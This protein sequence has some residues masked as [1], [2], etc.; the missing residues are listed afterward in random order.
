MSDTFNLKK[1]LSENKLTFNSRMLKENAPS[2]N[3]QGNKDSGSIVIT[4]YFNSRDQKNNSSSLWNQV[5]GLINANQGKLNDYTVT[6]SVA[7]FECIERSNTDEFITQ[8][9]AD[10][11][12]N[13]KGYTS[14]DIYKV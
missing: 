11:P 12:E 13:I 2:T 7:E 8:M 10:I 14:F 4:L 1:F 5:I 6:D 9:Q 3:L